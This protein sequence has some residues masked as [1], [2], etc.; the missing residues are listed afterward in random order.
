MIV[1]V[2]VRGIRR[3]ERTGLPVDAIARLTQRNAAAAA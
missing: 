2:G 1:A 3:R